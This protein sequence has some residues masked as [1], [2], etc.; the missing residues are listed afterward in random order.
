MIRP[1][2]PTCRRFNIVPRRTSAP[3]FGQFRTKGEVHVARLF[4]HP[5]CS[6]PILGLLVHALRPNLDLEGGAVRPNHCCVKRLQPKWNV[7]S[8]FSYSCL[9]CPSNQSNRRSSNRGVQMELF[10]NRKML[11]HFE[12]HQ[13]CSW[14]ACAVRRTPLWT[15]GNAENTQ[16]CR[17]ICP[18]SRRWHVC[19]LQRDR[20]SDIHPNDKTRMAHHTIGLASPP[21]LRVDFHRKSK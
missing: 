11:T 18:L 14:G 3:F 21:I 1:D 2:R 9:S 17:P 12:S 13:N 8:L 5:V 16:F 4:V 20:T 15:P 19:I 10:S 7:L 6:N